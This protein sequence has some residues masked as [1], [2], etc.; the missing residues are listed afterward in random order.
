MRVADLSRITDTMARVRKNPPMTLLGDD[1]T[2]VEDRLPDAD[3][4]TLRTGTVRVVIRPSGTEPKLK[5]Y[6]EKVEPVADG[7]LA[8]ARARA[9]TAMT[10]LKAEIAA[11][12]GL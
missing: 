9:E 8:A 6:L 3:V 10:A 5:A 7:G 1:V 11:A 12:L 4:L 2:E